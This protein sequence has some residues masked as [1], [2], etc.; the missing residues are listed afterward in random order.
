MNS[1]EILELLK[2]NYIYLIEKCSNF[3]SE[4]KESLIAMCNIHVEIIKQDLDRVEKFDDIAKENIELRSENNKFKEDR[5]DILKNFNN[6]EKVVEILKDYLMIK[7]SIN[8]NNEYCLDAC[9][10][11]IPHL[12]KEEYELLREVLEND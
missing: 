9:D 1:K 3:P 2:G 6:L 8:M 7:V 12:D 5:I 4:I 11:A 10:Y